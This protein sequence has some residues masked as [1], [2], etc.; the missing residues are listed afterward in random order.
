MA[1][2]PRR[3][4]LPECS[5]PLTCGASRHAHA[6]THTR[7][8]PWVQWTQHSTPHH[9]TRTVGI[10]SR[11]PHAGVTQP[12]SCTRKRLTADPPTSPQPLPNSPLTARPTSE[13]GRPGPRAVVDPRRNAVGPARQRCNRRPRQPDACRPAT[14]SKASPCQQHACPAAAAAAPASSTAAH[15]HPPHSKRRTPAPRRRCAARPKHLAVRSLS[16]E[17]FLMGF[18]RR[19]AEALCVSTGADITWPAAPQRNARTRPGWNRA[20]GTSRA[21]TRLGQGQATS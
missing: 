8:M 5:S 11:A 21:A 6:Y 14:H 18:K 3:P 4:T 12:T 9:A 19:R 10:S 13:R 15:L 1:G 20:G 16:L 7:L 17:A 2:V